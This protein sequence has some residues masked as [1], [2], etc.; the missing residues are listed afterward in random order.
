M[1]IDKST[2]IGKIFRHRHKQQL[3][4]Y[5][6]AIDILVNNYTQKAFTTEIGNRFGI[7]NYCRQTTSADI[8]NK[9]IHKASTTDIGKTHG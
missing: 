1:D 5:A 4:T 6:T 3:H 7:G 8:S 9:Y 2:D